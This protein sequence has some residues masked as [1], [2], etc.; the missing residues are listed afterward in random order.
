MNRCTDRNCADSRCGG[1]VNF[2]S[3]RR[4]NNI[5]RSTFEI[6]QYCFTAE[7]VN[8]SLENSSSSS[9][10]IQSTD[11][12]ASNT[13]AIEH[14]SDSSNSSSS[15][16]DSASETDNLV[17][18]HMTYPAPRHRRRTNLPTNNPQDTIQ[19]DTPTCNGVNCLDLNCHPSLVGVQ[20][21]SCTDPS[22]NDPSCGVSQ[23]SSIPH[24]CTD[25][26]C[27]HE[28]TN[29]ARNVMIG[30]TG[31]L[32]IMMIGYMA[33]IK[34]K[35]SGRSKQNVFIGDSAERGHGNRTP[36]PSVIVE[37]GQL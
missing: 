12:A 29:N 36:A 17:P 28:V 22:C 30:I 16:S 26:N 3:R 4:G 25:E 32:I 34:R 7:E 24:V 1:P 2:A 15:T 18:N 11:Q 13:A 27:N 20:E 21:N 8:A 5:S 33:Y 35:P 10:E 19:Q 6:P 31:L 23:N 9:S 37:N 14:S